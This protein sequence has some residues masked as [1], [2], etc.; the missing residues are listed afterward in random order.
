MHLEVKE[1]RISDSSYEVLDDGSVLHISGG[2]DRYG[3]MPCSF[4]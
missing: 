1:R 3:S 2:K 4:G